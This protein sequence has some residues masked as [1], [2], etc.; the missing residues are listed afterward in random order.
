MWWLKFFLRFEVLPMPYYECNF[1]LFL[2]CKPVLSCIGGACSAVVHG[3]SSGEVLVVS[4]M[5]Y[6]HGQCTAAVE[7]ACWK[8]WH[9]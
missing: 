3:G 7:M 8:V 2:V 1:A 4:V 9:A 6:E 5:A